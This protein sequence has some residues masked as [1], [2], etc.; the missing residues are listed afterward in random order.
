MQAI[1]KGPGLTAMKAALSAVVL[2]ATLACTPQEAPPWSDAEMSDLLD[3]FGEVGEAYAILD[4]CIP[5]LEAD[6]EAKY[7]LVSAIKADR[8]AKLLQFDTGYELKRLFDFFRQRGG[9]SE[10]NLALRQR[11]QDAWQQASDDI[12]SLQV[13]VDTIRDYANT[14]INMRVT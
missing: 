7:Q 10:Q 11:Y 4:I 12:T 3:Y 6:S 13:C 8:Y 2:I 9:T 5:M 14:M 1:L